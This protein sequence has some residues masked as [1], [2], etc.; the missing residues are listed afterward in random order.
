MRTIDS[1]AEKH[2]KK[3][4]PE[5]PKKKHT[6]GAEWVELR[7]QVKWWTCLK[8][9]KK[10]HAKK[11]PRAIKVGCPQCGC[12]DIIPL[13]PPPPKPKPPP[14]PRGGARPGAGARPKDPADLRGHHTVTVSLDDQAHAKFLSW[15]KG[16][17]S[18]IVSDAIKRTT[19]EGG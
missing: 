10:I 5:K 19:P 9:H 7:A 1:G 18:R 2:E 17:R 14:K 12:R 15:P 8:C 11:A 4:T 13:K 16:K 3:N 6:T